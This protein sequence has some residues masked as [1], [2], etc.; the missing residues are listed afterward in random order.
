MKNRCCNFFK[1]VKSQTCVCCDQ[2]M[3][4]LI[5]WQQDLKF[6]RVMEVFKYK[7]EIARYKLPMEV[8]V[9]NFVLNLERQ[10]NKYH[11]LQ[12]KFQVA[13]A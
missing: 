3:L 1:W 7:I 10:K 9:A 6:E 2:V 5:E 4:M 12:L 11:V 13:V 8:E